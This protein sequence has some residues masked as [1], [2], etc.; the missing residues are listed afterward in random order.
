MTSLGAIF[1]LTANGKIKH[2]P[3]LNEAYLW[4]H[5]QL[6]LEIRDK[7]VYPGHWKVSGAEC[8]LT[9]LRFG[10]SELFTKHLRFLFSKKKKTV[11]HLIKKKE[12]NVVNDVYCDVPVTYSHFF[13][14]MVLKM[15]NSY[16]IDTLMLGTVL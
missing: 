12:I 9:I 15:E 11:I 5:F 3:W 6:R 14:S 2:S 4:S 16:V 7:M 10:E 8:C 13:V 1:L